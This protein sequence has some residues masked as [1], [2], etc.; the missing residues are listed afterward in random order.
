[1]NAGSRNTSTAWHE[2]DIVARFFHKKTRFVRDDV[3]G[4][5]QIDYVKEM[6][7]VAVVGE[8]GFGK[9][10]AV[11]GYSLDQR[12]N[13]AEVAFSVAKGW[14]GK[15]VSKIIMKKLAA[16]AKDNGIAGFVA[17]TALSNR[18]MISVF[19]NLPYKVVMSYDDDMIH[20]K[21]SFDDPK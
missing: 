16:A 19:N 9:I 7:F 18:G 13:L 20:M 10:V 17:Y 14:Q 1:M 5:Y 6:T 3:S 12:D 11:G 8:F 21:C 15:G 2:N 4:F